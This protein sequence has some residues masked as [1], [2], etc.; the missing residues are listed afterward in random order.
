MQYI[1][2]TDNNIEILYKA[3]RQLAVVENQADLFTANLNDYSKGFIGPN[4]VAFGTLAYQDD[5]LIGFSIC[6]YKFATYIGHPVLYI[7][8]IYLENEHCTDENK[9][10]FINFL[11]KQGAERGCF[12]I[13]MRVLRN[14]NWGTRLL[15]NLG[16]ENIEKWSVYRLSI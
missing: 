2:V 5:K 4:P 11:I 12:R 14:V 9:R 7:E 3:N 13:E 6:N 15:N 8:D 10:E 1:P 16:F